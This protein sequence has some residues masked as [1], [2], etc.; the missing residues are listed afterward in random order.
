MACFLTKT[1]GKPSTNLQRR[2]FVSSLCTSASSLFASIKPSLDNAT[3]TEGRIINEAQRYFD[4][5]LG[6]M[7]SS[8][9]LDL[10]KNKSPHLLRCLPLSTRD[11]YWEPKYFSDMPAS[12]PLLQT[13]AKEIDSTTKVSTQERN[14]INLVQGTYLLTLSNSCN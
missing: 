10:Q 3:I 14:L 2:G 9:D 1:S 13:L 7:N 12:H 8:N 5:V 4:I 11:Q 6:A